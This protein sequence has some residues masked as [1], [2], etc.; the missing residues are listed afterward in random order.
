[1]KRELLTEIIACLLIILFI[2][3]GVTKLLD[4]E[5]FSAQIGQS[6]LLTK[7]ASL[8]AIVVPILELIV[9]LLLALRASRLIGFYGSFFL[10]TIF[11][12]YIVIATSF[13]DYV[14]CS[15]GGV[16]EHMTWP[17]HLIFNVAFLLLN[18]FAVGIYDSPQIVRD[19][20]GG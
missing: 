11:T 8:L 1:M 12:I 3:T 9:A 15:C 6:P 20:T 16:I 5:K 13:A 18:G 2:Y 4:F 17:Q 14:P 19:K 7:W 10:L